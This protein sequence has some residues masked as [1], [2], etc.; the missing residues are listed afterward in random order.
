MPASPGSES[1]A[2]P[3]QAALRPPAAPG[4]P[5]RLDLET[6]EAA[7]TP[8][9]RLLLWCQPHN[10]T[11]RVWTHAELA[12]LAA[13]VE[14]HDLL[15]ASD[16]LHC[17]LLLDEG[18]RHRPLAAT[19][20]PLA[21]RILTLWAPSKTFNLAG[22]T[23][24]CAVI[25]DAGLRRRFAAMVRG[26][27][28][29]GNVIPRTG[30]TFA[31]FLLGYVRQATFD[32]ELTTWL[33]RSWI[34]SFYFQDDWKVTPELTFNLGL[35][36]EWMT[37]YVDANF[38]FAVFDIPSRQIVIVGKSGPQTFRHPVNPGETITLPGGVEF[39]RKLLC[40]TLIAVTDQ[41]FEQ[42]VSDHYSQVFYFALSLT[43]HE[44]EACDLT[45]EA[46]RRLASKGRKVQDASRLKPWLLTTCYREFLRQHRHRLRFPHVEVGLVEHALPVVTPDHVNRID[47][48]TLRKSFHEIN[49]LYRF[50]VMLFYLQDHSYKEI[51]ALLQVPIGTVM[52]RLARGKEQLRQLLAKGLR[53]QAAASAVAPDVSAVSERQY[54]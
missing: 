27:Q 35:R 18:A 3:S 14:R 8:E 37:P 17:D 28:P 26:L 22:L 1:D 51:A 7:I 46:Y 5:W 40:D 25:P 31:G 36:W 13:L 45:Q 15:V 54:D 34:H 41:E 49:E 24:A 30:N 21:S 48:A 32:R 39:G 44:A 53:P 38:G 9:T 29:D 10:P 42:A 52:S 43:K 12:G 33:P 47:A 16:E 6:L 2:E 11:G 4:E 50:P 20:P 23:T 19:F